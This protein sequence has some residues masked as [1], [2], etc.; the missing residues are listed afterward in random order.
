VACYGRPRFFVLPEILVWIFEKRSIIIQ[1]KTM[2]IIL[3]ATGHVGSAVAYALLEQNQQVT[4]V[5]RSAE[6]A[7]EWEEKGAEVAVS[8]VHDIATL[9][10]IFRKGKRVFVLNP[11]ASPETDTDIE[12]HKSM[13]SIITALKGS[14]I[15]KI[16]AQ[17]TYGAQ[18]GER[19][20]DLG[21][22]YEMEQQLAELD[23]PTTILRAAYF[24]SNWDGYLEM[25][26][27]EGKIIS[28]YPADFTL[29]MVAPR[30]IGRFAGELLMEPVERT[31]LYNIEGPETYSVAD[32]ATAFAQVLERP[33]EVEAIN[34]TEWIPFMTSMG[35]SEKAAH[36][37]AAM[38][39]ITIQSTY[40][41]SDSPV[42]GQTTLQAYIENLAVN[43]VNS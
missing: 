26:D 28:F 2:F 8:D 38:T 40:E 20:G 42:K 6:K 5:T 13:Q 9:R 23:I 17:S 18:P 1:E 34:R 11:P 4:V 39:D 21:I 22:L 19:I 36:S 7:S 43:S 3:G 16:V 32:V 15:E 24:M 31:G 25:A 41:M 14:G 30:D 29:P 27:Q 10:E 35:F 12:E 33:V 37:M